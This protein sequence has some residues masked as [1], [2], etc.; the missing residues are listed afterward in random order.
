MAAPKRGRPEVTDDGMPSSP[1]VVTPDGI[2]RNIGFAFLAQIITSL[3]TAALTIYL[4]RALGPEEFGLFS[5]ALAIGGMAMTVAD[6]GVP[7]SA[8]RFVA[9]QRGDAGSVWNVVVSALWLKVLTATIVGVVLFAAAA[10]IATAYDE[11][12][13]TW[14]LR[15]MALALWGQSLLTLALQLFMALARLSVNLA[16]LRR[17]RNRDDR[18]HR[19]RRAGRR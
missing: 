11:P 13:L 4:V 19:A 8:A 16:D 3:F 10:E 2:A 17:E 14:P 7:S 12:D 18:Q 6:F 15:G 1:R 5:L 9:E